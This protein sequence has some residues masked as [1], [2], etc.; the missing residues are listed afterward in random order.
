[1]EIRYVIMDLLE[2]NISLI[3]MGLN[4]ARNQKAVMNH[5]HTIILAL[6]E[7]RSE[8]SNV[9]LREKS[10]FMP[11]GAFQETVYDL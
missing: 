4:D 6:S 9:K 2:Y 10:N 5:S 11:S 8:E 3:V 7:N 1:M